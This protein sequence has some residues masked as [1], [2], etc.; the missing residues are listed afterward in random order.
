MGNITRVRR[1]G[2]GTT[3]TLTALRYARQAGCRYNIL[4]SSAAGLNVYRRL[5]FKEYCPISIYVWSG[6]DKD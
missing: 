3:I 2:I 1:R 6:E 5:G 4:H